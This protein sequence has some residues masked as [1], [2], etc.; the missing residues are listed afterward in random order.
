MPSTSYFQFEIEKGHFEALKERSSNRL[1]IFTS[2][3]FVFNYS[4]QVVAKTATLLQSFDA[5]CL[6]NRGDAP[7]YTA[8]P[9]WGRVFIRLDKLSGNF[10]FEYFLLNYLRRI[11]STLNFV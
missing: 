1:I 4:K 5:L 2:I 10:F 3:V 8:K 9:R 11:F 6:F 7:I